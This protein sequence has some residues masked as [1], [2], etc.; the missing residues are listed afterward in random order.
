MLM[1]SVVMLMLIACTSLTVFDAYSELF[2]EAGIVINL[3][4]N[5]YK[6]DFSVSKRF[7][8]YKSIHTK[9]WTPLVVDESNQKRA[10]KI[11]GFEFGRGFG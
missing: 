6:E 7:V 2:P 10:L 9:M 1:A 8:D 4:D 11:R 5:H 3:L